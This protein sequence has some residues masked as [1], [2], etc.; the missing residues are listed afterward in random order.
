MYARSVYTLALFASAASAQ[1]W[2]ECTTFTLPNITGGYRSRTF[3]DFSGVTAD[4][5]AREVLASHGLVISDNGAS[6]TDSSGVPHV[7]TPDNVALTDGALSLKVSAYSGSGNVLGAQVSTQSQIK[8]AS[9]RTVQKSSKVP[10]VREGNFFYR[11]SN[12]E[13]DMAILTSTIFEKSECRREGIWAR[14]KAADGGDKPTHRIFDFGFDPTEDY[15]EYR[16]D[17][18]PDVAYF[19]IDGKYQGLI[20]ENVPS[21]DGHW[22]WNAWSNGDPCWSAGPPS[23]DSITQIKSIDI[24]TEY[25]GEVVGPNVCPL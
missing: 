22:M 6:G 25:T 1:F 23:A 17:W 5:D 12:A 8:Y 16:I 24:I 2:K 3:I 4:Q 18:A 9:V 13:I 14:T 15:H 21:V 10:G 19:Y 7:F 11:D 20:T